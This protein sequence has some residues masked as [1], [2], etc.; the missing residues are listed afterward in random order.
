M[1]IKACTAQYSCI[2]Y[3]HPNDGINEEQHSNQQAN[4]RQSLQG[5]VGS[6]NMRDYWSLFTRM[7]V[8]M[9]ARSSV[10]VRVCVTEQTVGGL[11]IHK[12][13]A[14]VCADVWVP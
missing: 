13:C 8:F 11:C 12:M 14:H 6:Q 4:I 3:L 1:S 10:F 7:F 9:L 5:T 2:A